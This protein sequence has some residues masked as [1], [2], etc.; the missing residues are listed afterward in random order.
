MSKTNCLAQVYWQK[1]RLSWSYAS[2]RWTARCSPF[3]HK[4]SQKVSPVV[5]WENSQHF[6]MPP[7]VSPWD[8]IWE[9]SAETPS[10]WYVTTQIWV[11]HLIYHAVK[12]IFVNQ[13]ESLSRS[14][15]W[16]FINVEFLPSFLRHH[17]A[18]KPLMVWQN[19][20]WFPRLFTVTFICILKCRGF[21]GHISIWN[22]QNYPLGT[23]I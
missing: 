5:H 10:W 1:N 3:G 17:F 21:D 18:G 19:F 22:T 15:L 11:V 23:M 6:S 9:M 12:E 7:L 14:E 4:F 2:P 8:K 16:D 20:G 13:S